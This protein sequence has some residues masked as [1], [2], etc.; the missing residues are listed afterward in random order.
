MG[1]QLLLAPHS[2]SFQGFG[3]SFSLATSCLLTGAAGAPTLKAFT[4]TFIF[5][6]IYSHSYSTP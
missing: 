5:Y 1:I 3:T 4:F 6:T 2:L